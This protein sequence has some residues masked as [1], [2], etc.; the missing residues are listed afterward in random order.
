MNGIDQ[1]LPNKL[2]AG[3]CWIQAAAAVTAALAAFVDVETILVSCPVI[4]FLGLVL[5][6]ASLP[7]ISVNLLLFGLSCPVITSAIALLI[8]SFDWGPQEA[9]LPVRVLLTLNAGA[10]VVWGTLIGRRMMRGRFSAT[11][12]GTPPFRFSLLSLLALITLTCLFF[13]LLRR[14]APDGERMF[15]AAYGFTGL[16]LSLV[17]ALR[18]SYRIRCRNRMRKSSPRSSSPPAIRNAS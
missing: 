2:L 12:G 14:L 4:A 9:S 1:F 11:S 13:A 5:A 15:F 7:R 6:S 3:A 10:T 8:A 18:Y 17:V 16:A